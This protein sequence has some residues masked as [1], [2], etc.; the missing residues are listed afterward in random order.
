MLIMKKEKQT[1]RREFLKKSTAVAI[2]V[3]IIGAPL[4]N[5]II[6]ANDRIR[7]GFIG[8]GNRGS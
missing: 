3:G 8:V 7:V 4:P 6:G 5:S 1:G 2:G